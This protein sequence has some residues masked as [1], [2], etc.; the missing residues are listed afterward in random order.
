MAFSL[1]VPNTLTNEW[2]GF[3]VYADVK[4]PEA[5]ASLLKDGGPQEVT[6]F[7]HCQSGKTGFGADIGIL[8]ATGHLV[9]LHLPVS[10]AKTHS[11]QIEIPPI[12]S[13]SISLGVSMSSR[14]IGIK[15]NA[16][17]D[18]IVQ[19]SRDPLNLFLGLGVDIQR[20][21]GSMQV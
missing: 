15:A 13:K 17:F 21:Q 12:R 2:V 3:S 6:F 14:N 7:G 16:D 10:Q 18:V 19:G 5:I 1:I 20:V 9:C 8:I 11:Q 4:T